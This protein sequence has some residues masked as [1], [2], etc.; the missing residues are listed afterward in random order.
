MTLRSSKGRIETNRN[1]NMKKDQV[2]PEISFEL[3]RFRL[4]IILSSLTE[5]L[6]STHHLCF[7]FLYSDYFKISSETYQI[8][9]TIVNFKFV[10]IPFMGYVVDHF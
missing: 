5:G 6:L 10:L 7:F 4:G 3:K 1:Y 8:F 9:E 2:P